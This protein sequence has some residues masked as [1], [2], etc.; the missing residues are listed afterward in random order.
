MRYR[1]ISI[2]LPRRGFMAEAS[3]HY[4]RRLR[5][6]AKLD[7]VG[8]KEAH[9]Q[10]ADATRTAE[11]LALRSA[12]SGHVVALDERGRRF[13]TAELARRVT[14]LETRGVSRLSLLVGGAEGHAPELLEEV[15]ESWSLSSLTMPHELARL[16]LLEQL[17]RIETLRA[18]HPYHRE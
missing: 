6:Y 18:G 2:G 7:V 11:S 3:D 5:A 10:G 14:E 17:Y 9:A 13:G 1:L 16:V 12:A 4:A 8:L 15:D